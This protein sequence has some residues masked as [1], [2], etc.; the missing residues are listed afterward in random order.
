MVGLIDF[1]FGLL[2]LHTKVAYYLEE[3][4]ASDQGSRVIDFLNF[5]TLLHVK[6]S[7]VVSLKS[8]SL[9]ASSLVLLLTTVSLDLVNYIG[10]SKSKSAIKHR[11]YIQKVQIVNLKRE[12]R[13]TI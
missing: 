7:C 8:R 12:V 2:L 9:A 13:I 10:R 11:N 5:K 6:Y 4:S 1:N 3:Q